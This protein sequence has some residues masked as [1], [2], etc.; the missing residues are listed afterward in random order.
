MKQDLK[1]KDPAPNFE[2][3]SDEGQEVSLH[4]FRGKKVILYFYPK[5]N[6]SG[7]TNEAVAFRDRNEE[8]NEKGAVVIGVSPDTVES[9]RKF[10]EKHDLNFLLLSDTD[11]QVA[12][13]F[14]VLK[15]KTTNG[16][17]Q[18]SIERSTFI[19]NEKG[20]IIKIFRKVKVDGH[21]NEVI[22]EL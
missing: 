11:R 20:V 22:K 15:E 21:V 8:I 1:E 14:G 10:R 16:K 6:T 13:A 17:K 12:F 9:H 3:P 2:L 5:D 18:L 7:W 4:N 19:I